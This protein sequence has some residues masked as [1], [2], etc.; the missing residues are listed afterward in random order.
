MLERKLKTLPHE[1]IE[2]MHSEIPVKSNF[3]ICYTENMYTIQTL[4]C[5][6]LYIIIYCSLIQGYVQNVM[7]MG[8]LLLLIVINNVG[9]MKTQF[10]NI[11]ED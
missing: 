5:Q 2:N 3:L 7:E 8:I 4:N 10:T 1:V 6:Y 9:G 11:S